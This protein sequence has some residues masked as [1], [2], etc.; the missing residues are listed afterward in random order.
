[1]QVVYNP[2]DYVATSS[3]YACPFHRQNPDI[4][5]YAG[6]TCSASWGTRPATDE[7]RAENRRRRLDRERRLAQ[8]YNAEREGQP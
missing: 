6:C 4:A 3:Y 1:M 8:W 7:E 5:S 2:D